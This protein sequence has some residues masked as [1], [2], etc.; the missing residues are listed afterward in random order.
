MHLGA[1]DALA[2]LRLG[3]VAKEAQHQD[4]AFPLGQLIQQRPKAVAVFD[5]FELLLGPPKHPAQAGGL[6]LLGGSEGVE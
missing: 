3:H 5:E 6:A 1:A 2:D 4:R